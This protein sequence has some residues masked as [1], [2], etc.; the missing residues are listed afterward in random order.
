MS[1]FFR[2]Q[3]LFTVDKERLRKFFCYWLTNVYVY[4]FHSSPAHSQEPKC[5]LKWFTT[6]VRKYSWHATTCMCQ[7][8]VLST[9]WLLETFR[10]QERNVSIHA[11]SYKV[12]QNISSKHV[13]NKKPISIHEFFLHPCLFRIKLQIEIP[14]TINFWLFWLLHESLHL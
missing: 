7:Q 10:W 5:Q 14:N 11:I 1:C 2:F 12:S 8:I 3:W 6:G 4:Y 9:K 13:Y